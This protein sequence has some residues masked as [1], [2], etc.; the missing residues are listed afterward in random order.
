VFFTFAV[1]ILIAITII[2][3]ATTGVTAPAHEI[4]EQMEGPKGGKPDVF[5][6]HYD[7]ELMK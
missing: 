6:D 5:K 7:E 1:S 2:T 4:A 3:N